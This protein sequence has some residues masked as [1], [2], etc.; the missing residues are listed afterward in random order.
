MLFFIHGMWSTPAVWTRLRSRLEAEGWETRAPV[1][2]WHD[3]D[4]SLPPPDELG[5]VSVQDY[6]KFLVD[7]V[8]L[9][10][11]PPV[12]IGH[13]MGG[14]LAQ[15]LAARV[16]HAGLVLLSPAA[17]ANAQAPSLAPARTLK[18]VV[19]RWGWWDKPTLCDAE[20]AR[21]GIFNN[22]P[23]AVAANEID[24]LVWDSGR[25]LAEIA[26]PWGFGNVTRVDYARLDRP[27]LVVVGAEDRIT[28][29]AG[30]RAAARQLSGR[31]DYQE[32]PGVGH[33]LFWGEVESRVGGMIGD[34]LR[35]LPVA[36]PA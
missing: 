33:W 3:R 7:E 21:W 19:L 2:P 34:W 22:V 35:T 13:S 31:L 12:I 30:A 5:R 26:L 4:A 1:L 24:A 8:A 10:P 25:V 28:P 6:V 9:L 29:P 32:L 20:G 36:D 18:N 14:L 15:L 17:A 23:D 27:T 11:G 16:D